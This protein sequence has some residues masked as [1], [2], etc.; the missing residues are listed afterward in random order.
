MSRWYSYLLR[1]SFYELDDNDIESMKASLVNSAPGEYLFSDETMAQ[2]LKRN[3]Q[4]FTL[5]GWDNI[6]IYLWI[7]KDY[8]W[9][10]DNKP[11]ALVFG[12]GALAWCL[13]LQVVAYRQRDWEEMYFLIS[14]MLWLFANFWWMAGETNISGDDDVNS[15][16]TSFMMETA[17]V[18]LLAFYLV[19]K[20][21][22]LVPTNQELKESF[23]LAGMHSRF[24]CLSNWREYEY[25]HMLCWLA[26]DLSWNLES[27]TAWALALIPTF[28]I[29]L[30]FMYQSW[31]RRYIVDF[32]HYTAQLIWV[33]ANA[34]WS[35]GELFNMNYDSPIPVDSPSSDSVRTGRWWASI[36]LLAAFI[37]IVLLYFVWLPWVMYQALKERVKREE[38]ND[39]ESAPHSSEFRINT[40]VQNDS[41]DGA[42]ANDGDEISSDKFSLSSTHVSD[43]SAATNS[44]LKP[45][46]NVRESAVH[47]DTE[48]VRPSTVE[49]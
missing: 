32:A 47:E 10:I 12:C 2:L 16:E 3:V 45:S 18:W 17:L 28:F 7:M 34:A 6:H 15:V 19:A 13:V 36:L 4:M 38:L 21:L 11:L 39:P 46:S 35:Y 49:C 37:P 43:R 41:V 30:D 42:A 44:V 20:P 1:R 9:T 29:G 31:S 48:E 22:D 5:R 24:T 33:L 14:M 40:L 23:E 26:K 25:L 8:A 27:K